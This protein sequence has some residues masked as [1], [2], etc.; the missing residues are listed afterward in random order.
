MTQLPFLRDPTLA[1]DNSS[2]DNSPGEAVNRPSA[3]ANTTNP[4]RHSI[5]LHLD[6]NYRNGGGGAYVGKIP[7]QLVEA[8]EAQ[9]VQAQHFVAKGEQAAN[10]DRAANQFS[11]IDEGSTMRAANRMPYG[12]SDHGYSDNGDAGAGS[13]RR[14]LRYGLIMML[15]LLGLGYGGYQLLG[16]NATAVDPSALPLIAAESSPVREKPRDPGGMEVPNQDALI[17]QELLGRK[18]EAEA[19]VA[20]PVEAPV[21][22]AEQIQQPAAAPAKEVGQGDG[23]GDAKSDDQNA[24]NAVK[25]D[26]KATATAAATAAV[27]AVTAA[28]QETA[29]ASAPAA[30]NSVTNTAA[31]VETPS[32]AA[33]AKTANPN[34]TVAQEKPQDKLTKAKPAPKAKETASKASSS[35]VLPDSKAVVRQPLRLQLAAVRSQE[36]AQAEWQRLQGKFMNLR[37]YALDVRPL[38]KP[39]G[40][41]RYR[42]LAGPIPDRA[43]ANQV[44]QSLKTSKQACNVVDLSGVKE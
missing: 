26:V 29:A 30:G 14:P 3:G 38:D 19:T 33:P 40:A 12:E 44:C 37:E 43:T 5:E 24:V 17:Y 28:A 32:A 42:V 36:D 6:P 1:L 25:S 15:A 34:G 8:A 22:V 41:Y 13:S 23:A 4:P 21:K 11:A 39:A 35:L 20:S 16:G 2:L 27:A 10:R 31:K 7:P 9:R 18:P